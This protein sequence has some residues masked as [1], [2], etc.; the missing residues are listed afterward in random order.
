MPST[1]DTTARTLR[2][3]APTPPTQ[4]PAPGPFAPVEPRRETD[5]PNAL[6]LALLVLYPVAGSVA[7][8]IA[9]VLLGG[10]ALGA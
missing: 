6:G 5:L 8:V 7:V 4:A 3:A 10:S 9:G 2:P 1:S